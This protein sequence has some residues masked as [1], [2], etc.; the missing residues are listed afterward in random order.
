MINP[1][2]GEIK[3]EHWPRWWRRATPRRPDT[4]Y[5]EVLTAPDL[6]GCVVARGTG[7]PPVGHHWL[8]NARDTENMGKMPMPLSGHDATA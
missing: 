5:A 3:L 8:A 2:G 6:G 7:V 1:A 4:V